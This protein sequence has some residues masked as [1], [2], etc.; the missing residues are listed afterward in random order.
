MW[1]FIFLISPLCF[2]GTIFFTS[3][4]VGGII[5]TLPFYNQ[6]WITIYLALYQIAVTILWGTIF[7]CTKIHGK[8]MDFS[9]KQ[10]IVKG[11]LTFVTPI[12]MLVIGL[13]LCNIVLAFL[14]EDL[15]SEKLHYYGGIIAAFITFMVTIGSFYHIMDC[16]HFKSLV[17]E[18]N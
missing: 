10:L 18:E 12:M 7:I 17:K 5:L 3:Y 6:V 14:G 11:F 9:P 13:G 8:T 15:S 4:V 2:L 16:L 1:L